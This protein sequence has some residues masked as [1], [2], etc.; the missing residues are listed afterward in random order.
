MV[1]SKDLVSIVKR[2]ED[3]YDLFRVWVSEGVFIVSSL[4]FFIGGVV[5]FFRSR[6]LVRFCFENFLFTLYFSRFFF[7]IYVYV[8]FLVIRDNYI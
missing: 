5:C 4:G 7:V 6:E 8:I 2:G 1:Y 3:S